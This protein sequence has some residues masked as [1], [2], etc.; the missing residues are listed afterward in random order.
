MNPDAHR[1]VDLAFDGAPIDP[2]A[3]FVVATNNY[4][5][6]GGGNF[7]GA[8][9]STV[10]FESPDTNRDVIVRFIVEQGTI[11]PAADGN[12]RARPRRRRHRPLRHRPGV[13]RLSRGHPRPR[14]RHRARRRRARRLRPLP[15]HPLSSASPR[16]D[17]SA[18]AVAAGTF[19]L[20]EPASGRLGRERTAVPS[21][22][23]VAPLFVSFFPNPR[24]FFWSAIVWAVVCVAGWYA[25]RRRPRRR[26]RPR[27]VARRRPADRRL[28]LL[29]RAVPVVLHLLRR[30]RRPLRRRLADASRRI[31][32]G[33][34]RSSARR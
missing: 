13:G 9:G 21:S 25:R 2:E 34:G 32:G 11:S 7:P 28:A 31:P 4:R 24:A 18:Q 3:R 14:R 6:G 30:R 15:H 23:S 26:A 12:W 27:R 10:I 16:G 8:D 29:V 5:A 19:A 22:R 33:A 17:R 20:L 1:I